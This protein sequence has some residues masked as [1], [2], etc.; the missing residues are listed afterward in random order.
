MMGAAGVGGNKA[1]IDVLTTL[2]LT[3][4]LKLC[5]DAGDSSSYSSGQSW[6]DRSG[7]GYDFH[8][9]ASGSSA[10]DDP[11]FNGS[12][13][14]LSNAEYMSTD[15]G[16]FF[17]Y[18]QTTPETWMNNMH[19]NNAIVAVCV[20]VYFPSFTGENRVWSTNGG[21]VASRPGT[22]FKST[23]GGGGK[24]QLFVGNASSESAV[25]SKTSD[26]AISSGEWTFLAYSL[27]EGTGS[28]GG[29]F[30]KNGA[31]AQV[32][33]SNTWNS[34]YSSPYSSDITGDPSIM[35]DSR[36]TGTLALFDS[37]GR[38]AMEAIWEGGTQITKAN[39]DDIY[40]NTNRDFR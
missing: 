19:K 37:G 40:E 5:L 12:A 33:S 9:G 36:N 30:Y 17:E 14:G 7:G 29:F 24:I 27:N 15:G 18:D 11:T 13:G 2:S 32:S 1:L 3:T 23:S 20:W 8:F 6:L 26:D 35:G 22:N 21:S 38:I 39:F 4:D 10:T 16:D 25:L 31:Y 34:T 28:G